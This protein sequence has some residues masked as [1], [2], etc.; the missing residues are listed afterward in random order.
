MDKPELL[1]SNIALLACSKTSFGN[2]L[3]PELKLCTTASLF[4][5]FKM[6]GKD[7]KY[8]DHEPFARVLR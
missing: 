4:K 7:T 1:K 2:T 8:L 6:S 3:G 5:I